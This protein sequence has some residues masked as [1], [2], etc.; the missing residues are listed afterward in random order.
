VDEL[1]GFP[2]AL[3]LAKQAAKIPEKEEVNLESIRRKSPFQMLFEE[4]P[5]SSDPGRPPWQHSRGT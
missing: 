3:R 5:P 2:E 1:G 4:G